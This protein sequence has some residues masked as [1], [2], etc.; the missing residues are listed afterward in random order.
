MK[1][2]DFDVVIVGSGPS[3]V[4]AAAAAVRHGLKVAL[5]DVGYID[6]RFATLI[7]DRPFSEIRKSDPNQPRFFL[8]EPEE[9]AS[10]GR[11]VGAHLTPPRRFV[12][13][14]TEELLPFESNGFAPMQS[15]ALGGLAAAWGAGCATY[16]DYEL[17]WAGLPSRQIYEYYEAVAK[18]VGVSGSKDD[19]VSPHVSNIENLQDPLDIDSNATSLLGVY[20][21]KRAALV[22]KGFKLGRPPLAALTKPMGTR[23]PNPY[24]DMD[25]W[26]DARE[27]VYRPRQTIRALSR[28]PNFYYLNPLLVDRF[29]ET[30]GRPTTV[31]A[32]H[33]KENRWTQITGRSLLLAAGAMNTARIVLRSLARYRRRVPI[34]CNP[35]TY[36]P[37]L[38]LGMLGRPAADRRHS[39]V[40]L[41]GIFAPPDDPREL[42]VAQFYSYR[43]LL[44]FRLV[45]EVPLPPALGLLL[46]RLIVTSLFIV[47]VNH[48]DKPS[49]R[50]YLELRPHA[51][52]GTTLVAH[53]EQ[54]PAER[55]Q[56]KMRERQLWRRLLALHCLPLHTI[57]LP[58]GASIHYAGTLP[59]SDD[60]AELTCT[61]EGRIRGTRAVYAA[62]GSPWR[63]L[64][65]KG[66]TFTL[67]ANA[68]RVADIVA[69]RLRARGHVA[70]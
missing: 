15:L 67:M 30:D 31:I 10:D 9:D 12:V 49:P 16:E 19:D 39:L 45:K 41:T 20:A 55:K 21:S 51:G 29:E 40:Q 37:V 18:D 57:P 25:F 58:A 22:A 52:T 66:L 32:R 68:R 42:L 17:E 34:L 24:H 13:R 56:Q 33:V 54:T 1:N 48:P 36:V 50:R 70:A 44:L 38:N 61:R 43:S 27:S 11:T 35:Y 26:S 64:S 59:F 53:W 3:G 5:V 69:E 14:D 2:S 65:S 28:E 63:Y 4:Q 60:D 23:Q 46:A 6:D 47:A 7:P 8:G 62:D